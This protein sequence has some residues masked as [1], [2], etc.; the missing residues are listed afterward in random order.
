MNTK[1]IHLIGGGVRSGKSSFAVELAKALGARRAFIATATRSDAEMDARIDR[2]RLDRADEFETVEEP[3]ELET[4]L[5]R[6][7][8]DVVVVDCVTHWLSN[9]LLKKLSTE[10]ILERVQGVV[11]ALEARR[12]HAVLVTNEVGM[13]VHPPTALGR[14]FVEVCGF[15][16]QRLA[17]C[18]DEVHL[19]VLG[20]HL[21]IKPQPWPG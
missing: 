12:C 8:A 20:T 16:H 2:H 11:Q 5:R 6:V 7:D 9:L 17:R 14:A 19:A 1:K 15:A 4:A 18:A 10:A 13:S 3:L 21:R